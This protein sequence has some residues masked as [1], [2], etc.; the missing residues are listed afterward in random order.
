M[1]NLVVECGRRESFQN[2]PLFGETE[3]QSVIFNS[4]QLLRQGARVKRCPI[5]FI[6]YP[7]GNKHD[8]NIS[9][10]TGVIHTMICSAV[11]DEVQY[12]ATYH[13]LEQKVS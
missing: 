12:G 6:M 9:A 1:K 5:E 2:R 3:F 13:H 7:K 11:A 4:G 10:P 8:H